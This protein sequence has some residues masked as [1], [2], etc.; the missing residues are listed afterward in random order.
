MQLSPAVS[1][2]LRVCFVEICE[3]ILVFEKG[4]YVCMYVC[5]IMACFFL[6]SHLT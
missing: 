1:L 3:P 5:M 6:P 4:V 2:R